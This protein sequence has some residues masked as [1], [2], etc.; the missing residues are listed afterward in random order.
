[1]TNKSLSTIFNQLD[2]VA[3]GFRPLFN[4]IEHR[5]N[6]SAGT[7]YPPCN[8]ST[9]D[10]GKHYIEIAV[11]GFKKDEVTIEMH[12]GK[13]TVQGKKDA[14]TD[15]NRTYNYKGISQRSFKLSWSLADYLE[16][17]TASLTDGILT[18]EL[19]ENVPEE[20]L[21]KLIDIS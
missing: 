16:V 14:D 3:L 4:E 13:L 6:A 18:I 11:A 7:N 9:T 1:M 15:T 20:A 17:S 19:T 8:V 5:Y 10:D 2:R 21:P 12:N